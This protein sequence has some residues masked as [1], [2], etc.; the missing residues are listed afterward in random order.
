[1]GKF[2]NSTANSVEWI[3]DGIDEKASPS[4]ALKGWDLTDGS[5]P[6]TSFELTA[7]DYLK[8]NPGLLGAGFQTWIDA[9]MS[10]IESNVSTDSISTCGQL[11]SYGGNLTGDQIIDIKNEIAQALQYVNGLAQAQGLPMLSDKNYQS[12]FFTIN[13]TIPNSFVKNPDLDSQLF[14]DVESFCSTPGLQGAD[15]Q[16]IV[17][18]DYNTIR[19]MANMP[20]VALGF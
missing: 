14:S 12:V 15:I 17:A 9:Q 5:D 18:T 19:E 11:L 13:N 2:N 4:M 1:L 20:P 16:K 3:D 8:S 6:A 7:E 10:A